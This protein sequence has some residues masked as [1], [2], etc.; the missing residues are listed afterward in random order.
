MTNE[1]LKQ[2]ENVVQQIHLGWTGFEQGKQMAEAVLELKSPISVEIGC[3]AGRGLVILGLAHKELGSGLA[4]GIDP[5]S[6]AASMEDEPFDESQA[7]W[8]R[9]QDHEG[10]YIECQAN[11]D[12]FGVRDFVRVIRKRSDDV[13]PLTNIGF[14]RIDG[15][16]GPT[17]FR[18]VTRYCP[19]VSIGGILHL[20]DLGWRNGARDNGALK[21]LDDMAWDRI[22]DTETGAAFKKL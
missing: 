7:R 10:M 8:W 15:N 12:R 20:D 3:A 5:W 21:Y 1:L 9:T 2:I 22:Y 18:D 13:T 14:L 6:V 19:F 11:I 17:S 4:Y 16:H